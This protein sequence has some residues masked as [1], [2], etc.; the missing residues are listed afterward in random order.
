VSSSEASQPVP[1]AVLDRSTPRQL[2]STSPVIAITEANAPAENWAGKRVL[3]IEGKAAYEMS[4]WCGTCPLIFQRLEGANRTLSAES[5]TQRLDDGLDAYDQAAAEAIAANLQEAEYLPLLLEIHPRLVFPGRDGDYF[6]EEQVETWGIDPFWGLPENPRTPYYRTPT[7]V[8]SVD[9]LLFEFVVPLVPPNWN[10]QAR[11]STYMGLLAV[12]SRPT[13]VAL[14]VLDVRHQAVWDTPEGGLVHWGLTHYLLDGH[15]K[16]E[17]AAR[18][19]RALRLLSLISIDQSLAD[20]DA[21]E[22]LPELLAVAP[23]RPGQTAA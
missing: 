10:D 9:Q 13:C 11:V 14:G 15:H 16:I 21:M 1:T 12:S 19:G 20:D 23:I 4:F 7:R 3:T 18:S 17:A 22:R 8:V 5:L 6:S 2:G